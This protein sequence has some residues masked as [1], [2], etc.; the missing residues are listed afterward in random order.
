MREVPT[1]HRK[2]RVCLRCNKKFNSEGPSNRICPKCIRNN[3]GVY[4]RTQV[5]TSSRRGL[6]S[7]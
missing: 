1:I 6:T 4:E 5:E 7:I 3:Q 2:R